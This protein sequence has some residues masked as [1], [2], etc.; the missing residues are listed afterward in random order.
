M[1]TTPGNPVLIREATEADL[2]GVIDAFEIVA[3]EEIQIGTETPID[4]QAMK[5][6]MQQTYLDSEEAVMFVALDAGRIVGSTPG[7]SS[8]DGAV[9]PNVA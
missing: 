8:H 1:Q 9:H 2:D 6:R 7:K 5:Q 3:G 4:R